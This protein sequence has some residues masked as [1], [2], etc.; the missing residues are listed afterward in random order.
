[1]PDHQPPTPVVS[2]APITLPAPDR[3][4]DL[5]VRVSAPVDGRNLPVV[6][7]AHGFGWSLD[8]YAPL[9]QAWAAAGF[10]VLQ[11]THLDS[12]RLGLTPE[13]PRHDEIWRIRIADLRRMLD[14]LDVLEAAVPGLAGRVDHDRVAV[15][16][17]SF[18]GQTAGALLGVRVLDADGRPGEDLSDP[19]I[20]AG[21][22]L[23]SGGAGGDDL[24]AF[25]REHFPFMHP[26]FA[27]LTRPALVVA[28]D[29][30]DS[31]LT[32]RGPDWFADPYHLSPG[33][34]SLLTL[35]GAEHTLGGVA[36]FE[37]A[38]T[39]DEHPDRVA[40][41]ARVTVAYLQDALGVDRAPWAAVRR[42]LADAA[43]PHARLVSKHSAGLTDAPA[44][45]VGAPGRG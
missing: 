24:S 36:G 44:D 3:G 42:E 30:D 15:A 9:V 38:E 16:G 33:P 41:L 35:L 12:R 10:V 14:D 21:V 11:T 4:E 45:R 31:F 29:R 17:H 26:S 5:P 8:G 39:T 25:A 6:L 19:R 34:K 27:G 23:A 32:T 2:V 28:G 7:L 40:L 13:D 20:T 18:G 43:P 37:V 1:V 22:L